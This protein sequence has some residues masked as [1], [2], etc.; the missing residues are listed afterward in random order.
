LYLSLLVGCPPGDGYDALSRLLSFSPLPRQPPCSNPILGY[1]DDPFGQCGPCSTGHY[2][3]GL[4]NVCSVRSNG[5]IAPNEGSTSC[6]ACPA[7]TISVPVYGGTFCKPCGHI[8]YSTYECEIPSTPPTP[9]PTLAPDLFS[10]PCN[11][12]GYGLDYNANNVLGCRPCRKG[13]HDDGRVESRFCITCYNS[14]APQEGTIDCIKCPA[15]S[16]SVPE[17]FPSR[18]LYCS[19]HL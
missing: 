9:Q 6:T 15:G 10:T 8:P 14:I 17:Y 4:S 3:I 11:K 2:N 19:I 12:P 16:I 5:S 1:G 18:G 13:W 7:E